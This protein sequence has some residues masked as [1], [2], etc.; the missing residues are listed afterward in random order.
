MTFSLLKLIEKINTTWKSNL[1][2]ILNDVA[3]N[4]KQ[5]SLIEKL[6]EDIGNDKPV[7]PPINMIFNSMTK[8]N[9]EEKNFVCLLCS[10]C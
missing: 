4:Q 8:F 5:N 2:N 7:Y 3:K 9:F 6:V 1:L 10:P